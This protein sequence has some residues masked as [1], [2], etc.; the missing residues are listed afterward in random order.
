VRPL[1]EPVAL[2]AAL[3]AGI[4]GGVF[5][6][7]SVFVMRALADLPPA[8]GVAAMQRINIRV[9][10]PL[11][12][13]PFLGTMPM[14]A[15]ATYLAHRQGDD[16]A[17][18][19]LA[20]SFVVYSVGSVGVTVV[21]NVPRNDRLAALTAGSEAADAYWPTY[22]REWVRLNHVRCL[23]ALLASAAAVGALLR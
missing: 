15:L 20:T 16:Q 21:G 14:L 19:W 22:V 13:G 23:A 18:A 8:H 11:F 9:L 2:L 3:G 7:F 1:H 17:A 10:T 5:L 12:L 6:A 4:S